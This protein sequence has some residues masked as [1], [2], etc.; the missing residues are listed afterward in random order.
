MDGQVVFA[1]V[2]LMV[3]A[4]EIEPLV[5]GDL[6][7]WYQWCEHQNLNRRRSSLEKVCVLTVKPTHNSRFVDFGNRFPALGMK[8]DVVTDDNGY[9]K[10]A[11]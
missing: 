7:V 9:W 8:V 11:L 5:Q 10:I 4:L 1:C 3:L 6:C 2:V